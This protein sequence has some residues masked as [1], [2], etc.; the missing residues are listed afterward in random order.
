MSHEK[1]KAIGN[2]FM[3]V[4][5][6]LLL[7]AF[8]DQLEDLNAWSDLLDPHTLGEFGSRYIGAAVGIIGAYF[9]GKTERDRGVYLS[10][11]RR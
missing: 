9:G 3:Y 5:A 6:L 4:G 8:F 11:G 7:G 2:V 10:V 1:R